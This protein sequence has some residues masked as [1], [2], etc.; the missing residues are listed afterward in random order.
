MTDAIRTATA[1]DADKIRQ[2]IES[3]YAIWIKRLPDLPDVASGASGEIEAGR[4]HVLEIGG[5]VAGVLNADTHHDTL[6]VMNIA[7]EPKHSG[8]GVG[9]AL[10]A[11]AETLAKHARVHRLALA[12]HKDMGGNVSMYEHLGWHVTGTKGNKVLMQRNLDSE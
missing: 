4:M 9:R 1:D 6:H 7:V 10:I 8:K 12:T 2:V 5:V 11:H 3:A